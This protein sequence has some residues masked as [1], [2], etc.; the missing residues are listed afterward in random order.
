MIGAA[1]EKSLHLSS[2]GTRSRLL[3]RCEQ[4]TPS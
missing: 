3:A 4:P 1:T 2:G